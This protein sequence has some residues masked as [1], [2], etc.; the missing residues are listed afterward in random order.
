MNQ[1]GE[2]FNNHAGYMSKKGLYNTYSLDWADK[3]KK[4]ERVKM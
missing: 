2:C 3:A 4:V 1:D